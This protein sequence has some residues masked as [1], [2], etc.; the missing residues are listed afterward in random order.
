MEDQHFSKQ[1]RSNARS[2]IGL[3]ENVP[4]DFDSEVRAFEKV[5]D[6]EEKLSSQKACANWILKGDR[7]TSFFHVSIMARRRR[8]FI[9]CLKVNGIDCLRVVGLTN[10]V[11]DFIWSLIHKY[12]GIKLSSGV[13]SL[14]AVVSS[15]TPHEKILPRDRSDQ[16]II[17][18]TADILP[19]VTSADGGF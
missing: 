4:I 10:G 12:R 3:D 19:L 2:M 5:K 6:Q 11:K 7:N 13:R 17:W 18:A 16:L 15:R 14:L 9:S 8:D 1:G